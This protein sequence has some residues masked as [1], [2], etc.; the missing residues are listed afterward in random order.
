IAANR[1]RSPWASFAAIVIAILWTVPIAGL[2]VTSFRPEGDINTSGWWTFL[3]NPSF[4][5]DNYSDAMFGNQ[6][7]LVGFFVNSIVITLPAVV[8]PISIALLA[9]YA[10]AWI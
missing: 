1:L 6:T 3:S 9:A 7:N 8:I 4:T 2:L 5:L 10:F